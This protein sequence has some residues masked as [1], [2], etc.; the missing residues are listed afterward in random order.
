MIGLIGAERCN[1]SLTSKLNRSRPSKPSH[2]NW[3]AG[4]E[5]PCKRPCCVTLKS[6]N[7]NSYCR[8]STN[9]LKCC[10]RQPEPYHH[11][12]LLLLLLLLPLLPP[13]QHGPPTLSKGVQVQFHMFQMTWLPCRRCITGVRP[14]QLHQR[15]LRHHHPRLLSAWSICMY[16]VPMGVTAQHQEDQEQLQLDTSL[17]GCRG[18]HHQ[19][20]RSWTLATCKGWRC[21]ALQPRFNSRTF[22]VQVTNFFFDW[23]CCVHIDTCLVICNSNKSS[24][25]LIITLG[26]KLT[27]NITITSC[28]RLALLCARWYMHHGNC[29]VFVTQTR[30]S[31]RF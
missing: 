20:G 5:Q 15:H 29:L 31:L 27:F 21:V 8:A 10:G 9:K 26:R 14:S 18:E 1:K 7:T 6:Q 13:Q 16:R 17:T 25:S 28:T 11:L 4:T 12:L 24:N 3:C 30:V 23:C 19:P 22:T 2:P